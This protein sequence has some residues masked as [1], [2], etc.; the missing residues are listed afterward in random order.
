MPAASLVLATGITAVG[1]GAPSPPPEPPAGRIVD[2]VVARVNDAVVTLSELVAQTGLVLLQT[3][4]ADVAIDAALSRD[5]LASVLDVV[6]NETLLHQEVRRLQL[7]PVSARRVL[8]AYRA[9]LD[10]LGSPADAAAFAM[11]YGFE[12][13]ALDAPPPLWAAL[14]QRRLEVEAFLEAR[15]RLEARPSPARVLGC[16]EANAAHFAGRSFADA[17]PEIRAQIEAQVAA[18]TA[19]RLI[20]DLRRRANVRIA[21]G[22]EAPGRV[23]ARGAAPFSCPL[24]DG[25]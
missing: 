2:M 5:L 7:E 14:L 25:P 12:P 8:R 1:L 4:G 19:E 11:T 17:E 20:D 6:V 9:D 13:P 18:Q 21:A 15:S 16:Y 24:G 3:R 23:E 22:F 10:R